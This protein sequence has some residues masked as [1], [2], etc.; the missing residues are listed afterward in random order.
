MGVGRGLVNKARRRVCPAQE[1]KGNQDVKE[2]GTGE[3]K[4][5]FRNN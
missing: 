2:C 1:A 4:E 3:K 5:P